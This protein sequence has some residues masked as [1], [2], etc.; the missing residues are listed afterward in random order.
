MPFSLVEIMHSTNTKK[1]QSS[2]A[3]A[4]HPC[5][6]LSVLFAL[7]FALQYIL[8]ATL[9]EWA[10]YFSAMITITFIFLF[11]DFTYRHRELCCPLKKQYLNEFAIITPVVFNTEGNRA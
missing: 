2:R 7:D 8:G 1:D 6:A 5:L 10:G 4:L 11:S 9:A 3:F